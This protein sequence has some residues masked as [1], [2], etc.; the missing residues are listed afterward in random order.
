M[1]SNDLNELFSYI[2]NR[3]KREVCVCKCVRERERNVCVLVRVREKCVCARV[4]E[5][6]GGVRA[7]FMDV[8]VLTKISLGPFYLEL[9]W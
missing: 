1:R 4:C 5:R 3:T 2:E 9:A 8:R 7:R 6:E